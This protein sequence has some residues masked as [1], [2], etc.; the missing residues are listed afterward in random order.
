MAVRVEDRE[1]V[2]HRVTESRVRSAAPARTRSPSACLAYRPQAR[3]P[4]WLR[5]LP[6]TYRSRSPAAP[7]SKSRRFTTIFADSAKRAYTRPAW[8]RQGPPTA[9]SSD[10]SMSQYGSCSERFLQ[11]PE[12]LVARRLGVDLHYVP[13]RVVIVVNA[14]SARQIDQVRAANLPPPLLLHT[15]TRESAGSLFI[16]ELGVHDRPWTQFAIERD[17]LGP[18]RM[19]LV[20]PEIEV[21]V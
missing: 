18:I 7:R 1:P 11:L 15:I 8:P 6:S 5:A 17:H 19:L 2:A 21:R 14:I 9:R 13:R 3:S 4:R 20:G 12:T 16:P 10:G